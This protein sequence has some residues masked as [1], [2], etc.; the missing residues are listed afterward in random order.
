MNNNNKIANIEVSNKPLIFTKKV[1]DKSKIIP[2]NLNNNTLGEKR[3]FPPA[4]KE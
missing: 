1:N 3:H 2:L 4:S